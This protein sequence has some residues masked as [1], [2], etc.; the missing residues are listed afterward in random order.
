[1]TDT[2][3]V[4]IVLAAGKG[5]RIGGDRPKQLL[6]LGGRPVVVHALDQ[7]LRLGHRLVV[8]VSAA[9]RPAIPSTPSSSLSMNTESP[10]TPS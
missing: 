4:A 5:E 9:S 2:T 1:M 3:P 8:V 10:E 6:D 7:H